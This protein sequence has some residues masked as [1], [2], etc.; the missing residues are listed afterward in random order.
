M[1]P[2]HGGH[3]LTSAVPVEQHVADVTRLVRPLT[4]VDRP[5][6]EAAGCALA[7]G[8][9]ARA[10]LPP[11]GNSAMDGY[12][13][14]AAD[15]IGATADAPVTLPVSGEIAAGDTRDWTV[16]PG[17]CL[18]IMTGARLPSGADAIVPVEWT[19]GGT[20]SDGGTGKV[21]VRQAAAVG[22]AVRRAGDD[23]QAGDVL[24]PAGTLLGPAQLGLAAAAGHA[25]L[26]VRARPRVVIVST[27]NE[28]VEPGAPL[29]PGQIWESNSHLL[30]AAARQAGCQATRVP[31]VPD[32]PRAL[33]ATLEAQLPHA[34]LL[35]T[36]GG[37]SMGG[38]N[39]V[40]KAALSALGTVTFRKVL[41]QP[42]MPQGFGVLG[43]GRT[44]VFTLP[45]NPVSAYVSFQ[46]FV[47]P[48]LD[49][50][51]GTRALTLPV[52]RAR[53]SGPARAPAGRRAYLRGVLDRAAGTVAPLGRQG[54][55]QLAAL[56]L[57]NAL[58]IAPE[59][60]VA[61]AEND[62]VDVLVLP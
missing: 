29:I 58:I 22:N 59:E 27:G 52:T 9:T 13:V 41:V 53:L 56:G 35:I 34:D 32:D 5:L 4:P 12:A 60:T 49:A 54:S 20:G 3:D 62:E 8:L 50:L 25:T 23:A 55:H 30:A 31:A 14:R 37:V 36:S 18:R 57:A 15:V 7:A 43:P 40:V 10:A 17:Q 26:L 21:T 44:P 39:D 6:D 46:I 2:G 16:T 45:G 24:L 28:L 38:E 1:S 11:F 33:L 61:L 51:L 42:G 48:A 47:R 19:D